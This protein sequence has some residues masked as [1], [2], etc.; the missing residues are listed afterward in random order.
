[1]KRYLPLAIVAL[2]ALLALLPGAWGA[3]SGDPRECVVL[4]HGLGRTGL[5][6]KGIEWHL[7]DEGYR[8][9]NEPYPSLFHGLDRLADMAVRSGLERCR[10][11]TRGQVSFV[12][13]S[14]GGILV[15][16]YLA[17]HEVPELHR[18]VMLG[19]PNQGSQLAE[20]VASIEALEPIEP[21]VVE[22]LSSELSSL[23]SKLGPV[24]FE[25]G[26]IAGNRNRRTFTPG[27][28]DEPSDGT[29]AVSE[30]RVEGMQDFVV[31]PVTHTF[32]MW[33]DEVLDQIVLFL[34]RGR[35]RHGSPADAA[36][37][38][39]PKAAFGRM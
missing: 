17:S 15:R 33:D 23:T 9:V 6:M 7:E 28:P 38:A 18:V 10:A 35:F 27:A 30:T 4:L 21:E 12:T 14:L 32:M 8:V 37:R 5:S 1:L 39:A 34:R 19:P 31:L 26:V 29:V 2:L 3:T 24:A 13:H 36:S 22:D 20:Y 11:A 25:L 16:A